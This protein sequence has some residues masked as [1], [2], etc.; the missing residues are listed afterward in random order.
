[1]KKRLL[2]LLLVLNLLL[3]CCV[4]TSCK[5]LTSVVELTKAIENTNALDEMDATLELEMEIG[6]LETDFAISAVADIKAKG[7]QGEDPVY[8]SKIQTEDTTLLS[9]NMEMYKEGH[10]AYLVVGDLK[11]KTRADSVPEQYDFSDD[12]RDVLEELPEDLLKGVEFTENQ[13]GSKT[14]SVLVEEEVFVDLYEDLLEDVGAPVGNLLNNVAIEDAAVSI[15]I[16]NGFVLE[17]ALNF[18]VALINSGFEDY[19]SFVSYKVTYNN[20]GEPVEI[21]PPEG[22]Q[23][24]EA[25]PFGG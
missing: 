16:K 14:I 17:Y 12:V 18:T 15:T 7:L 22:Y 5:E 8:Y 20:P 4:F 23:D 1:M 2:A 6:I 11:Y 19:E 25:L 3:A 24:F 9:G 13:D 10:L 21:T